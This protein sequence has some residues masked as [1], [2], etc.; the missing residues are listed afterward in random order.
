MDP[1]E[2]VHNNDGFS[3]SPL[4][5]PRGLLRSCSIEKKDGGHPHAPG[6]ALRP[7]TPLLATRWING[8]HVLA[9]MLRADC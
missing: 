4:R 8:G 5:I 3:G 1:R 6:R 2:L 7:C 9:S